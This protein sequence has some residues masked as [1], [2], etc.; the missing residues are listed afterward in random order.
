[1]PFEIDRIPKEI[2]KKYA[3]GRESDRGEAGHWGVIDEERGLMMVEAGG[4]D[5]G[6]ITKS[7][8]FVEGEPVIIASE[9]T[10]H[11]RDR[12]NPNEPWIFDVFHKIKNIRV[13]PD[14][15]LKEEEVFPLVE[16]ALIASGYLYDAEETGNVTITKMATKFSRPV[17]FRSKWDK[18]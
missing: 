3:G 7:E 18:R 6:R 2:F 12:D 8:L 5:H 4:E 15:K 14:S 17:F 11:L 1:M 13:H 16:E 10:K 9:I